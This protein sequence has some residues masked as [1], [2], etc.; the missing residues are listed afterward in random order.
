VPRIA[1]SEIGVSRT[2]V[3]PKRSSKPTLA[4]NTPPAPP[5]SSPRKTTF[6]SRS[7]SCAIAAATASRYVSSAM[8]TSRRPRYLSRSHRDSATGRSSLLRRAIDLGHRGGLD[9]RQRL[10]GDAFGEQTRPVHR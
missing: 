6:S 8:S 2:R 10:L 5:M 3:G 1:I 7:I 4:L 9:I